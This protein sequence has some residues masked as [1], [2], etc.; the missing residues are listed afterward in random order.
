[1]GAGSS[2]PPLPSEKSAAGLTGRSSSNAEGD[3]KAGALEVQ[4]GDFLV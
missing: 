2:V 1:M 3:P 4:D